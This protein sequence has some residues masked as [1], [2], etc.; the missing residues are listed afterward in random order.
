MLDA[1]K[2][3]QQ[4]FPHIHDNQCILFRLH[5]QHFIEL[6]RGDH[7][8]LAL[9]Y[10]ESVLKPVAGKDSVLLDPLLKDVM[11]LLAYRNPHTSSV[12]HLLSQERRSSLSDDIN[13]IILSMFMIVH[14][15]QL[16][17]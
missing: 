10:M 13:A 12:A 15:I 7:S 16:C 14:V 3:L 1:I 2:Y 17:R 8:Y 6:V 11:Q 4:H 5:C 9:E